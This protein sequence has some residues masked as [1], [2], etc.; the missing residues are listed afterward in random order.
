ME[1]LEK[2]RSK[3]GDLNY[4]Q[5]ISFLHESKKDALIHRMLVISSPKQ[6][7]QRKLLSDIMNVFE[8]DDFTNE[9]YS[10]KSLTTKRFLIV[11]NPEK[12]HFVKKIL[13]RED[14]IIKSI[15]YSSTFIPTVNVIALTN[16]PFFMDHSLEEIS[17]FIHL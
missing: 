14:C 15:F 4:F 3:I 2:W 1:R 13:N 6:K 17:I 10:E 16:I 5:L 8:E 12:N 9:L 7:L 11:K